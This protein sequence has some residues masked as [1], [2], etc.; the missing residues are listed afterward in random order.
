M[1]HC[2]VTPAVVGSP[3]EVGVCLGACGVVAWVV[4]ADVNGPSAGAVGSV[5]GGG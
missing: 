4:T 2:V 3:A 1:V 5:A